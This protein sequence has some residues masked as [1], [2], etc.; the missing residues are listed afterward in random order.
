MNDI[1]TTARTALKQVRELVSGMHAVTLR[2]EI[3]HAGQILAA[4][5]MELET[6]GPFEQMKASPLVQNLLGLC[7]REAV[8]NVVKHSK[9]TRCR[10]VLAEEASLLSLTVEDNGRGFDESACDAGSTGRGLLGMKE[11]LELVEGKLSFQARPGE[12]ARLT[13]SVP[14]VIKQTVRGGA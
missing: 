4:A 8:T 10:I 7:L 3:R 2:D 12:G 9:A 11:R 1:Q 13:L 14:S 5:D 6:S